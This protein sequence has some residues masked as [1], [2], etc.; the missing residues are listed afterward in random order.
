M[1]F[2]TMFLSAGVIKGLLLLLLSHDL[3]PDDD[4]EEWL[5]DD[6]FS[7]QVKSDD[8][9]KYLFLELEK[10]K[11]QC[12][13]DLYDSSSMNGADGFPLTPAK[14]YKLIEAHKNRIRKIRLMIEHEVTI[15]KNLHKPSGVT[16]IVARSYWIDKSG[17]KVRKFAK[18]LGSDEKVLVNGEIPKYKLLDVEKEID[19][20]MWE[21][22]KKEYNL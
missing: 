14:I 20:M 9:K 12:R 1:D 16:Y 6:N 7:E 5:N 2:S 17:K 19:R 18:N 11:N 4:F 21:E 13:K 22:Y 8:N 15:A 10:A 3:M